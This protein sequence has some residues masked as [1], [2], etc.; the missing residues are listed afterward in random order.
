MNKYKNIGDFEEKAVIRQKNY[1]YDFI[2]MRSLKNK[3][4]L[5]KYFNYNIAR[6]KLWYNTYIFF[7]F[8]IRI[9]IMRIKCVPQ[10]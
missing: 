10:L 9:Y 5:L 2:S 8:K 3:V 4:T 1:T 6:L 7:F